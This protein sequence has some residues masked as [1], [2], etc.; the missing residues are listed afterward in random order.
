MIT[1]EQMIFVCAIS[2]VCVVSAMILVVLKRVDGLLAGV[3]KRTVLDYL[4]ALLDALNL[5]GEFKAP[6]NWHI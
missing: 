4:R 2:A 3:Y 1:I 6:S 5:G